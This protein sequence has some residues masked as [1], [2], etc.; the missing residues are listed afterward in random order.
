MRKLARRVVEAVAEARGL[1]DAF[2]RSGSARQEMPAQSR[3]RPPVF[4][5]VGFLLGRRVGGAIPRVEAHRDDLELLPGVEGDDGECREEAVEDLGAEHRA[6]VVGEDENHRPSSEELSEPDRPSELVEE[7]GVERQTLSQALL[8]ADLP[9]DRR[10]FVL[11]RLRRRG[12]TGTE[13]KGN[14][15]RFD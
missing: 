9:Q 3:A 10:T 8:D 2:D 11:G 12:E 5:Q 7:E 15:D 6:V 4:L 13:E 1:R 14:R